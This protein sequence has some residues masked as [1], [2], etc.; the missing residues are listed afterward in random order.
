MMARVDRYQSFAGNGDCCCVYECVRVV[1]KKAAKMLLT[2]ILVY[3]REFARQTRVLRS[4]SPLLPCGRCDVTM[5]LSLSL[6]FKFLMMLMHDVD[7][8]L[9]VGRS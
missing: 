6:T 7:P 8:W 9:K 4:F 1:V 5:S 3:F 2:Y